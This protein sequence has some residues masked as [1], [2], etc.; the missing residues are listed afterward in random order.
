MGADFNF[1][2]P[3]SHTPSSFINN[4]FYNFLIVFFESSKIYNAPAGNVCRLAV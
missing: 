1:F 4:Q 2:Q 3:F